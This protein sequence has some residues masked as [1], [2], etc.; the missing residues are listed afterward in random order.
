M[1]ITKGMKRPCQ[2]F[3]LVG[4]VFLGLTGSGWGASQAENRGRVIT[5]VFERTVIES[6]PRITTL[7]QRIRVEEIYHRPKTPDLVVFPGEH[8][9][10]ERRR[11]TDLTG[12]YRF[13]GEA[14][15]RGGSRRNYGRDV[16]YY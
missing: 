4:G 12:Q 9:R 6:S 14:N 5:P 7:A 13:L 10:Y 3:Y 1:L 2:I 8:Q 11:T 16:T 15:Y